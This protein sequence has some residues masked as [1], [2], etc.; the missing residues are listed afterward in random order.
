MFDK[1][2]CRH[3]ADA[4]DRRERERDPTVRLQRFM[5]SAAPP[6]VNKGNTNVSGAFG[7]KPKRVRNTRPK[8]SA[9]PPAWMLGS[10][11]DEK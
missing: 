10:D 1:F 4:K 8:K 5:K 2:Q 11:Q 9:A 6:T 3:F 7:G